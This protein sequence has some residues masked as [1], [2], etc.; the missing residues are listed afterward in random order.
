M[1]NDAWDK[2]DIDGCDNCHC[3]ECEF[4]H[5]AKRNGDI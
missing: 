3:D 2:C 5:C 1:T 4:F